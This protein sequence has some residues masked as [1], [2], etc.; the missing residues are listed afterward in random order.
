MPAPRQTRFGALALIL[1]L[2]IP[3]AARA[4]DAP[5]PS[6]E[7]PGAPP[8]TYA[9]PPAYAPPP[10]Y[11]P[12]PGPGAPPP[13]YPPGSYPP[14]AY[15]PPVV[16][17]LHDGF[18]LRLH[19]GG[20]YMSVSGSD[21]AG[22]TVKIAGDSVSLG[23]SIGGAIVPNLIVFGTFFISVVS[24]PDLTQNGAAAGTG[25]GS[26]AVGG[27]GAGLA[28]Y[29]QPINLYLSG[30]LAATDFQV[31]DSNGNM[32]YDSDTGIGFQGMVGKEWWVSQDWGLGAAFE[33][34]G[35]SMKDKADPSIKWTST[36][37]ALLF[38]ATYN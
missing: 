8:P 9:P 12:T 34:V 30:V 4:Q 2:G 27:F 13:G 16:E 26:A 32:T 19:T 20:G 6:V 21:G 5:A 10:G 25:S 24:N 35:A 36:S 14:P 22:N 29:F 1:L 7:S 31:Q 11:A 17:N 3:V 38:S 23:V 37:F 33:F 18:Y 28:Y 15:G